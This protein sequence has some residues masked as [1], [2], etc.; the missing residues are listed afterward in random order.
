MGNISAASSTVQVKIRD[1]DGTKSMT[2][3]S[4]A[5]SKRMLRIKGLRQVTSDLPKDRFNED[6]QTE[7]KSIR[8]SIAPKKRTLSYHLRASHD[9]KFPDLSSKA[10]TV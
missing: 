6:A 3:A 9:G 8:E 5:S 10:S 2:N 1:L 4:V 7:T